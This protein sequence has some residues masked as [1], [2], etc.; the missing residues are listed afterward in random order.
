MRLR[1][2]AAVAAASALLAPAA[3]GATNRPQVRD[4]KGDVVTGAAELDIVSAQWSTS[5]RGDD[6]SLVATL[7]LAAPPNT[8]VPYVYE[9]SSKVRDCGTVWFRYM[10][11]TVA[12]YASGGPG[13]LWLECGSELY[14]QVLSF[15]V[16]GNTLTWSIPLSV[17]PEQV[18]PGALFYD[19]EALADAGEPAFGH[20]VTGIADYA[21]DIAFGDGTWRMR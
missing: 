17:L 3:Q 18:Q 2:V 12:S 5:G 6:K 8:G 20:S 16:R 11:G 9:M 21:L 13:E 15:T 14:D 7:T 1:L 4:P 19:F 10:P